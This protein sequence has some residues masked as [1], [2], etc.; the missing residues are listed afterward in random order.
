MTC[1][2]NIRKGDPADMDGILSVINES[3]A[4]YYRAIIPPELFREPMLTRSE[5]LHEFSRITFFCCRSDGSD[6]IIGVAALDDRNDGTGEIR[7]VYVLPRH[8]GK[9]AGTSLILHIEKEAK[10]RAVRVLRVPVAEKATW[11]KDFYTKLGYLIVHEIEVPEGRIVF[12]E[13]SAE[14][15]TA[16]S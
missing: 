13:R 2:M 8:E 5:M 15:E 4:H 10:K 9:G 7:W 3:N 6:R 11:A 14:H 1:T 12:F 16:T